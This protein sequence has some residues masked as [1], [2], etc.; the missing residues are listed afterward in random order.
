M[1]PYPA[2]SAPSPWFPLPPEPAADTGTVLFCL[3]H[4]GAGASVYRRWPALLADVAEVVPVQ[5]P[6]RE[7]RFGEPRHTRTAQVVD[8]LADHVLERAAR[9]P[10]LAVFGH[11]MG[12][13]LAH[14]LAHALADRGRAPGHLFVSGYRAPSLP[15]PSEDVHRLPREELIAHLGRMEGTHPEVLAHPELLDLLL[16]VLRADYELCETHR[17]TPRP[18]LSAPVTAFGGDADP[19]V[20]PA[21]LEAWAE[22]TTG[23]FRHHLLPGGHFYLNDRLPDVLA[24]LADG[25]RAL[26]AARRAA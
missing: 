15:R 19:G 12:A 9:H 18:P 25:L 5:L 21:H 22:L 26:P 11:S 8:A 7:S 16:P 4:A 13:L 20:A 2:A 1:N 23:P 10:R 6:G 24:L 14:E 3:P 17:H